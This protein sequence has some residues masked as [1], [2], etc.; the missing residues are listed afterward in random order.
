VDGQVAI[1]QG[2]PTKIGPLYLSSVA[3]SST[4]NLS[5]LPVY[6]ADQVRHWAIRPTSLE[7]ARQSLAQLQAKAD[8]CVQARLNPGLTTG[9]EDCP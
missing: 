7:A 5:D 3:Q 1:F 2:V 4:V 9:G 8:V 6:Y